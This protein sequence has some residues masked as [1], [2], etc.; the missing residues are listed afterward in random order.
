MADRYLLESGTSDGYLLE[1]GTGV[2]LLE[3]IEGV[4]INLSEIV[5]LEESLPTQIMGTLLMSLSENVNIQQSQDLY[6][7]KMGDIGITVPADD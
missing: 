3:I 1:D 5:N 7:L 4:S 2:L 6:D